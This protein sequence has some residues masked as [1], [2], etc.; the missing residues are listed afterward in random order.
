MAAVLPHFTRPETPKLSQ[1][2]ASR[3]FVDSIRNAELG[4]AFANTFL[5]TKPKPHAFQQ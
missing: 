5:G 2:E 3:L 1:T 4:A